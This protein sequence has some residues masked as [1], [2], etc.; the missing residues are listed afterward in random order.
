MS[1]PPEVLRIINLEQAY[2]WT[3]N[4]GP[5]NL[6]ELELQYGVKALREGALTALLAPAFGYVRQIIDTISE[7]VEFLHKYPGLYPLQFKY[8][9]ETVVTG[10]FKLDYPFSNNI[11]ISTVPYKPNANKNR[12]ILIGR[13]TPETGLK[14]VDLELLSVLDNKTYATNDQRTQ[15]LDGGIRLGDLLSKSKKFTQQRNAD[16]R[17]AHHHAGALILPGT[18]DANK[19]PHA[20]LYVDS[21]TTTGVYLR[22][23]YDTTTYYNGASWPNTVYDSHGN[24]HELKSIPNSQKAIPIK[25]GKLSIVENDNHSPIWG[26]T[27]P[28][29][30]I[31]FGGSQTMG[32]YMIGESLHCVLHGFR[33]PS[34]DTIAQTAEETPYLV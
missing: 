14:H 5:E 29:T 6:K 26:I 23:P 20:L 2:R 8:N 24:K 18:V 31:N 30:I 33:Y 3:E 34:E 21:S 10:S 22:H 17:L 4:I 9:G 19:I 12:V 25:I 16:H 11:G 32:F 7:S 13:Q 15:Q 1:F 27:H 28:S